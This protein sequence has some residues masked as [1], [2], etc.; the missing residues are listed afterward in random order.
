MARRQ[1]TPEAA[2]VAL[3]SLANQ[4][5]LLIESE[6]F[7]MAE[8]LLREIRPLMSLLPA[9]EPTIYAQLNVLRSWLQL[10]QKQENS[11][12]YREIARFL[13]SLYQEAKKMNNPRT[14]SQI[15]G[16]LGYLYGERDRLE[17]AIALTERALDIAH[18]IEVEFRYEWQGQLARFLEM[19]GET[20]T[21]I[22]T[23]WQAIETFESLRLDLMG[24]N[25]KIRYN[26][27]DRVEPIYRSYIRLQLASLPTKEDLKKEKLE[28]VKK[29]IEGLRV[30]ELEDYLQEVC[31]T[32][33]SP[34][35][36]EKKLATIYTIILR[37]R[38]EI[39][40]SLPNDNLQYYPARIA[41]TELEEL[42]V[43]LRQSFSPIFPPQH[44]RK[45]ARELYNK[46]LKPIE[47]DL[48]ANEIET[49]AFV[50][51]GALQNVPMSALHDGESYLL[52]EYELVVIPGLQLL[53]ERSP[54]PLELKAIAA[55]LSEG[56]DS[57]IPL[58]AVTEEVEAIA[59]H[60]PSEILLNEQLTAANLQKVLSDRPFPILHL[61]THG[62]FS[63]QLDDTFLLMWD[64]RLNLNTFANLLWERESGKAIPLEL[65]VLSA[66]Q[67]A[68]GDDRA[69]LGLAGMSVRSGAR[70]TLAS[71]WSVNDESTA[72][73]M[74]TFYQFLVQFQGDRAK[75]LREAQLSLLE[76]PAFQQPYYW[77]PFILVGHWR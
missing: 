24:L 14:K 2:I 35:E 11:A 30:V 59:E 57:F 50:P 71:L 39:L 74:V 55:G 19:Q 34:E 18:S 69:A 25:P 23:Y 68:K 60:L 28:N 37:D 52:E 63:S 32:H 42:T 65:L 72:R 48:V 41:T 45:Y 4:L 56:R 61:A 33:Q 58:P 67:T 5:N 62:Q 3:E 54:N 66:C 43:Q 31:L 16:T 36:S 44:H 29:A 21:A 12:D 73:L 46:I 40:A 20:E 53:K 13:A 49:L 9:S 15:L 38:V 27:R 70:S 7:E 76:D 77:A 47:S 64:G 75:A 8:V 17:D 51:D 22:A 1:E 10:R 26:F 6:D